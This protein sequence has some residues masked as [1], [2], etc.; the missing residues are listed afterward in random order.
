MTTQAPAPPPQN[1]ASERYV[2]AAM[3]L[4]ERAILTASEQLDAR[5]FYLPSHGDIYRAILE[6]HQAGAPVDWG[7]CQQHLKDTRRYTEPVASAYL[8][9]AEPV[10]A[11][12]VHVHVRIV[13][14]EATKYQ[15]EKAL[16]EQLQAIR[17]GTDARAALNRLA[18]AHEQLA[19]RAEGAR[20][21][22]YTSFDA[23][24]YYL[25]KIQNPPADT[26]GVPTPFRFLAPMQPGRLHI[27]GGYMGDGKT[28]LSIQF[29]QAACKAGKRVA[30]ISIEMSWHDLVDRIIS[31]HG[32]PYNEVQTARFSDPVNERIAREAAAAIAGWQFHIL[33]DPTITPQ[34]I[35]LRAR[36]QPYD[37][38][39]I[40]HLHRFQYSERMQIEAHVKAV[41]NIAREL[42]I[43]VLLLAQFKRNDAFTR[44]TMASFRESAMIEAE[45]SEAWLIYRRRDERL[46]R[47][48]EA[49]LI[50]G[51][52]RF[53]K[54]I[55]MPLTFEGH[56][57]RFVEPGSRRLPGDIGAAA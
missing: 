50:S 55:S 25:D 21:T 12:N 43:P 57:V 11:S 23:S 49:E 38:L 41:T 48:D 4:S 3:L 37:L 26:D 6:L 14:D 1:Q 22:L 15:L 54:E 47:T 42:E 46:E 24:E 16:V 30:F 53:G 18:L 45:A 39:I 40:D 31:C 56:N 10:A 5:D 35:R 36:Q 20:K 51:K 33:D 34:G 8:E 2:L 28:V 19:H 9:L 27:L 44:P 13:K 52:N 7:S 29:L 32:V 17:E